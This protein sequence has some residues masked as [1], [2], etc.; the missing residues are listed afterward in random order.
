MSLYSDLEYSIFG[1]RPIEL[2]KFTHDTD[3]WTYSNVS[4]DVD[5]FQDIY[6]KLAISR[7]TIGQ[8]SEIEKLDLVVTCPLN[9]EISQLL[10]IG[11]PENVVSLTVFRI[12]EGATGSIVAWKGRVV[13]AKWN[14]GFCELSCDSVYSL[15]KRI[16]LRARYTRACRHILYGAGCKVDKSAYAIAGVVT[17]IDAS[18]TIL[19]IAEAAG[20]A[21]GYFIAGMVGTPSGAFR[22]VINHVGTSIYLSMPI[23][24]LTVGSAIL[25]YP[26]CDHSLET[27]RDRFN[28]LAN[29]GSFAWIPTDNP[30]EGSIV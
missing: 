8:S 20:Q 1:G 24:T 2:Y 4:K 26:G 30:F 16:G 21:D 13:S 22:F 9:C 17:A 25:L 27:C 28:N 19:T 11:S 12:H 23:P 29:N 14:E 3:I 18:M 7:S 6:R 10:L 5:F 15:Q